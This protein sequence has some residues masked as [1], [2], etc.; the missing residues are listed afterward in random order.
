MATSKKLSGSEVTLNPC[1]AMLAFLIELLCNSACESC[2]FHAVEPA[3]RHALGKQAE[4]IADAA[5]GF[6]NIAH[7]EAHILNRSVHRFDD[8]GACVVCVQCGSTSGF[9]FLWGQGFVEFANSEL[10]TLRCFPQIPA[11][12]CPSPRTWK[13]LPV[14]RALQGAVQTR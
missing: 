7:A 10:P 3:A 11:A 2:E 13:G 12:S 5:G 14:L 9:V 1:M 4:E 8:C 6:Q